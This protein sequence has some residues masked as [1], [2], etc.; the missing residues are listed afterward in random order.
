MICGSAKPQLGAGA[1]CVVAYGSPY[2]QNLRV[3]KEIACDLI[4]MTAHR[5]ELKDYLL[6]RNAARVVRR[7]GCS[8]LEHFPSGPV[9][10]HVSENALVIRD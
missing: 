9:R 3:A 7:A 5:P 8:V 2:A 10:F 4:I 1:G 6:G